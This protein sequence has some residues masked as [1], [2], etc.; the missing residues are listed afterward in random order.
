MSNRIIVDVQT[1]MES[2]GCGDE[3]CCGAFREYEVV[4]T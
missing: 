1:H 3:A 2:D 4:E